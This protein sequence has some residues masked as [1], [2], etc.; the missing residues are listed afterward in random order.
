MSRSGYSF[1]HEDSTVNLWLGAVASAIK[2]KRG[3]AFLIET[4][5]ALDALPN[6]RLIA[7]SFQESISGDFCTLGVVC[8]SR[9]LYLQEDV[10]IDTHSVAETLGI[11]RALGAEVMDENDQGGYRHETPEQRWARMRGWV[12]SKIR[13]TE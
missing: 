3:Q 5:A 12:Q 11:S 1:D 2:G 4:L 9:G 7:E 8:N 10:N 6:K 13:E